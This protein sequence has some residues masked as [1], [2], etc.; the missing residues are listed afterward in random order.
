MSSIEVN[1]IRKT[2]IVKSNITSVAR[3]YAAFLFKSANL[4]KQC[5]YFSKKQFCDLLRAHPSIFDVFIAGFH[6]NIWEEDKNG[7]PKYLL[8]QDL[9]IQGKCRMISGNLAS[10]VY[11]KLIK[12]TILVFDAQDS[13]RPKEIIN[14]EG[15]IV[16]I[17][18]QNESKSVSLKHRDRLYP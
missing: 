11:L 8:P 5:D 2:G 18:S 14:L 10:E 6:T 12:S 9:I 17:E 1:K 4:D 16:E 13:V 7:S 3:K 15:L